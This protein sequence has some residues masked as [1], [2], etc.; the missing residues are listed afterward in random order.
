[1]SVSQSGQQLARTPHDK[2]KELINQLAKQALG[3]LRKFPT[4]IHYQSF[5]TEFRDSKLSLEYFETSETEL[6][7][8]EVKARAAKK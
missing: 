3:R 4:L 6:K 8:L 1:M 5:L 7:E 2:K